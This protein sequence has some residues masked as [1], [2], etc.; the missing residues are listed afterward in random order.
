VV[1]VAERLRSRMVNEFGKSVST[2]TQPTVRDCQCTYGYW[3][4]SMLTRGVH[5]WCVSVLQIL[6]AHI[7]PLTN[8][9]FNKSGCKWVLGALIPSIAQLSKSAK[10]DIWLL[11]YY[12]PTS[13]QSAE[14]AEKNLCCVR[15]LCITSVIDVSEKRTYPQMICGCFL[16]LIMK[17]MM[18]DMPLF[19]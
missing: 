16:V 19:N 17:F 3:S 9:A 14:T 13:L 10:H 1:A 4:G 6:R 2:V 15:K 12:A 8:V 11:I 7:L 18:I 5:D